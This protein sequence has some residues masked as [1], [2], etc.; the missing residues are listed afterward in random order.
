M[1]RRVLPRLHLHPG[2]EFPGPAVDGTVSVPCPLPRSNLLSCG[3]RISH[4][5]YHHV[6]PSLLRGPR[7]MVP[8]IP[9][10]ILSLGILF[11]P[12]TGLTASVK[13]GVSCVITESPILSPT[14]EAGAGRRKVGS[15]GGRTMVA[16]FVYTSTE[17]VWMA[18]KFLLSL[19][20]A[21]TIT[22]VLPNCLG[23]IVTRRT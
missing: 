20:R 16:R 22:L 19:S 15:E 12:A 8:V 9:L 10:P 21:V 5:M 14:E 18:Y 11:V 3:R 23:R 1:S 2:P 4:S 6:K 17:I 7:S 13:P